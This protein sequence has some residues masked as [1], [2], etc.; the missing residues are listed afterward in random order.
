VDHRSIK[1]L[2]THT[3]IFVDAVYCKCTTASHLLC[4]SGGWSC[5]L[6]KRVWMPAACTRVELGA[7]PCAFSACWTHCCDTGTVDNVH[8][9]EHG[10]LPACDCFKWHALGDLCRHGPCLDLVCMNMDCSSGCASH[11][12]AG[13]VWVFVLYTHLED[14]ANVL[15]TLR[16]T[17]SIAG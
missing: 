7:V 11:D 2:V 12:D 16:R 15:A 6:L 8:V 13:R 3:S 10:L 14:T 4:K 5:S 17:P 1:R 9:G